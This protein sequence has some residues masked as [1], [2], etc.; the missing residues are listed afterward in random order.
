[1]HVA[2]QRSLAIASKKTQ[3]DKATSSPVPVTAE[4]LAAAADCQGSILSCLIEQDTD[5]ITR[6]HGF[7]AKSA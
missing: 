7:K 3:D 1:M 6:I 5:R 2:Q 4:L